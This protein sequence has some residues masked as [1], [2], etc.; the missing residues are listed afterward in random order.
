[1]DRL[2]GWRRTHY[3]GDLRGSDI[4]KDVILM[5][6]VDTMRDH[7]G[8]IFI[9]L[10][11]RYGK[12]QVV[13]NPEKSKGYQQAHREKC[14]QM[15]L[16]ILEERSMLGCSR[17][18]YNECWAALDFHHLTDEKDNV[19]WQASKNLVDLIDE[20]KIMLLCSNCHREWHYSFHW[21]YRI[22]E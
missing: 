7:G 4:G 6:W 13:F 20:G 5:G 15:W 1:M 17:C 8:V 16:V 21:W 9:D 14:L 22:F 11:D 19:S 18:G 12:T 2:E 10:R 3:C